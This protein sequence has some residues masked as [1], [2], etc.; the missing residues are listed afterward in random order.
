MIG[1][2]VSHYKILEKLGSGGM[3]VVYKA[4]DL[5][6]D[7]F[8]ALKFLPPHLMTS[9]EDRQRF[10]QEAKT[11]SAL[12][13]NNICA[14]HEINQTD[15]GRLFISMACYEGETLEDKIKDQRFK[16]KEV[17]DYVVQIAGGLSKA[18]EKGIVHRDIKP[19]NIMLTVDG[20]VKILDFG[21]A[22]LAEQSRLTKEL[23]TIGTASYMSPEQ[24]K[25][26]EVD[27]RADVWSLGVVLYEMLTGELPFKGQY[28]SAIIY[29]ILNDTPE[30]VTALREDIPMELERILDKCL[31]KDPSDRYQ[32]IDELVQDLQPMTRT[33]DFAEI[34]AKASKRWQYP[35]FAKLIM[36]VISVV[37]V[38]ALGYFL[39]KQHDKVASVWENSIAVLPFENI[40][41]EPDQEYFCD[42]MTEQIITNLAKLHKL[43]VISR[44]SVMKYKATAKTVPEIGRELSVNHILEGSVRK[45]GDRLRITAQLIN[46]QQDFSVWTE[47]YDREY[48]ELFNI[49]DEVSESIATRLLANLSHKDI[50]E[51][52]TNRPKNTEAYEYFMKGRYFHYSKY[53]GATIN[54]DDFKTSEKM[55]LKAI[56]LDPTYALSYANLAD[57]YNTYYRTGLLS[58]TESEYYL[59]RERTYLNQAITLDSNLVEVQIIKS[60]IHQDYAEIADAYH[61]ALKASSTD[62]NNSYANAAMARFL[63]A[64]GLL[65]QAHEYYEK[66]IETDPLQPMHYAWH[67]Y[68]LTT[69]GK[70]Q[71]SENNIKQALEIDPDH[72][73]AIVNDILLLISTERYNEADVMLERYYPFYRKNKNMMSLRALLFAIQG[74]KEKALKDYPDGHYYK[75]YVYA[76]L[77]M[78]DAAIDYLNALFGDHLVRMEESRYIE[79]AVNPLLKNLRANPRF[80]EILAN[81]KKLYDE[82]LKKYGKI[83]KIIN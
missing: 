1:E 43:K 18:H 34:P 5:R 32:R 49:Q 47:N 60:W 28:D 63:H 69:M 53:W 66:A 80:Q 79:L 31:Q 6:L 38:F 44:T 67:S 42:G 48:R 25:G 7:R 27:C 61:S 9:D 62:P 51:I 57:L 15:E 71:A 70:Y 54:P 52:K 78:N 76:V 10:I 35:K 37:L 33:S 36:A 26:S 16:I 13:H 30:P 40:S 17:V 41:N 46:T 55:F 4:L 74:Q 14:I 3:G 2:T 22:K 56:E 83:D 21:L 20:V 73:V 11:V 12:D 59:N 77:N 50:S 19:A 39:I 24:T 68:C 65:E 81:H 82:N 64:R 23:T 8:V 58:E 75:Y 72:F 29:S 45:Y